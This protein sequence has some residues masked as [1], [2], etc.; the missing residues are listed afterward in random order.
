M[1]GDT[2]NC[3]IFWATFH[4]LPHSL[5]RARSDLDTHYIIVPTINEILAPDKKEIFRNKYIFEKATVTLDI[6]SAGD[7]HS[8]QPSD[9]CTSVRQ[10]SQNLNKADTHDYSLAKSLGIAALG[11]IVSFA[12]LYGTCTKITLCLYKW[13]MYKREKFSKHHRNPR[14]IGKGKHHH[15]HNQQLNNY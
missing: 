9:Y 6:I 12:L 3:F 14:D 4:L 13:Q 2:F 1:L 10:S 7:I 15:P 5:G 8:A 11:C